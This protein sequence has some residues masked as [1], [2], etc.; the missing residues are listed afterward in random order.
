MSPQPQNRAARLHGL[1]KQSLRY[2][3][4][5]RA[6]VIGARLSDTILQ[7]PVTVLRGVGDKLAARL[8]DIGIQSLED[9]LFHFP[10]RYQ[11]RTRL[12]PDRRPSRSSRRGRRGPHTCCRRDPRPQK[13]APGKGRGRERATHP[14]VLSFSTS[15]SVAIQAGRQDTALRH[16]A[17]PE[18]TNRNDSPGISVGRTGR[19][20]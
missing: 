15:A 7:H 8:A 13:N 4:S 14:P 5:T 11:D 2:E 1:I 18:R 3:P 6:F 12:T 17:A 19:P 9:L 16:T 20:A 10:L